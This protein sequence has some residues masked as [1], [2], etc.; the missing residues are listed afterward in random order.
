MPYVLQHLPR[1]G[2]EPQPTAAKAAKA[3]NPNHW[4]GSEPPNTGFPMNGTEKNNSQRPV[5]SRRI[6]LS[7]EK[8]TKTQKL[9]AKLFSAQSS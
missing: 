6:A 7:E 8:G 9:G 4:A 3:G 2:T 1:P 5:L